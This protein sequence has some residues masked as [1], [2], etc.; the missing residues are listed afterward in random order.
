MIFFFWHTYDGADV[1]SG[2]TSGVQTAIT[3]SHSEDVFIHCM[4]Y[5]LSLV[6]KNTSKI[7][8]VHIFG[9]K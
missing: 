1:M 7:T 4:D 8:S 3:E 6:I 5:K 9:I 2:C